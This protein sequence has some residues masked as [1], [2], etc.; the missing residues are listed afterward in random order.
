MRCLTSSFSSY[1]I[2]SC[3]QRQRQLEYTRTARRSASNISQLHNSNSAF[4]AKSLTVNGF[5]RS[6]RKQKRVAFAA[7][8]DGSSVD[9]LQ[10]VLTPEQAKGL[11]TGTAVSITGNW[12][13]SPSGK[14]QTYELLADSVR[15]LGDNDAVKYHTPN[16]L[17]TLPHLRTRTTYNSLLLRLRSQVIGN[18]TSFFADQGFVQTHPPIITSSDC[19]GAGEVFTIE[20]EP[21]SSLEVE[22]GKSTSA[23]PKF[24]RTPKYLTVS[25]QLHLEALAQSV[26]KVWALSPTFR[27]ERSDTPRHLSEFYMLEA[28]MCFVEDVHEVM[29]IVESLLRTVGG[30]LD[31]SPLGQEILSTWASNAQDQDSK[32]TQQDI[33]ARWQGLIKDSW[34]RITYADAISRLQDA[35]A[36]GSVK[37]DFQPEL[38]VGLQAEHE[39]F[40]AETVGG[41]SPVFVTDYPRNIKA[42]YMAPSKMVAGSDTSSNTVACFDL[43]VPELCEIVGGSMREHRLEPLLKAM[44]L[45]GLS[46]RTDSTLETKINAADVVDTRAQVTP[47][48]AGATTQSS[49]EWYV[50]LRRYGSVPHG[51]FGIGFDRLLC[52]LSGVSNIRD[53]VSFP[54]WSIAWSRGLCPVPHSRMMY[55]RK[56]HITHVSRVRWRNHLRA[57]PHFLFAFLCIQT[58]ISNL[59]TNSSLSHS[60]QNQ[61]NYCCCRSPS[62]YFASL[63]SCNTPAFLTKQEIY[64]IKSQNDDVQPY[65][66]DHTSSDSFSHSATSAPKADFQPPETKKNPKPPQYATDHIVIR[67]HPLGLEIIFSL[68]VASLELPS[69]SRPM[70]GQVDEDGFDYE[71]LPPNFSLSANMAAGAFAG[72][73]E[74]SVMYPIDL[75]KTRMQVVNPSP[76]AVYSG[77]SNAMVT[78]SRVEGFRTLWRGVSSPAH[79]VYFATYEA[80]KNAMGGNEGLHHEHHPLAAAVSGAAATIASDAL[81]NPFDVI[82]QRMQLQNSAYRSLSHC[83][84]TM[85][86]QEGLTAFYLSYP[87]TLCMTVPFTALQFMAYESSSKVLNPTGKYDPYTHCFAGAVAGGLA[88]GLTTPLDV[89]KTLLQTR[90]TANDAELRNVKGLWEAASIIKRRDGYKGFFRGLK[91]RIVTTM[92]STAICWS[93]YEMAKAFFIARSTE[94]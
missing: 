46:G 93:A 50:D 74:H 15:A 7:I 48:T 78:I 84:R 43:L 57:Y 90:G 25:S 37:F 2:L 83:A 20:T 12:Q 8:T 92:P 47:D 52:Y 32:L 40:I 68:K 65:C 79:A 14:E 28:E 41:G 33:K 73:A 72:I 89:I 81:M 44:S 21:T 71:S 76:T 60:L 88:A 67:S 11:S 94:A 4:E 16:Y 13:L 56:L 31:S 29:D 82:K 39:K 91:P 61:S 85:F 36:R 54:R 53:V 23:P 3:V 58:N 6:I 10:A 38:G 34:P 66:K 69:A 77:I 49:L 62:W 59:Q 75:L 19:E 24:F 86:K 55:C 64:D 80:V 18:V 17:R 26:G 22:E 45:H 1:K 5:V 42:F 87:T 70:D 35:A 63:L 30:Q 9:V 51:G 27:A